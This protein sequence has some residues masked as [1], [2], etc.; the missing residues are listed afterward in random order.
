MEADEPAADAF[1]TAEF[2]GVDAVLPLGPDSASDFAEGLGAAGRAALGGM[3]NDA[4]T[5]S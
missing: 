3:V 1:W 5:I 4:V 2:D